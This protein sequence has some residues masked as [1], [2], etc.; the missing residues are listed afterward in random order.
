MR[1]KHVAIAIVAGLLVSTLA[2]ARSIVLLQPPNYESYGISDPDFD[3]SFAEDFVLDRDMLVREVVVWGVR[4]DPSLEDSFTLIFR[5]DDNGL[6]GA[7]TELA[8]NLVPR[9]R[10]TTGQFVGTLA[11]YIYYIQ[12]PAPVS[13][14]RGIWWVEIFNA[15]PSPISWGW[16]GGNWDPIHGRHGCAIATEAP[17]I[18]WS[19]LHFHLSILIV[20]SPVPI[21]SDGFESGD[22]DAWSYTAPPI[23]VPVADFEYATNGLE[24]TFLN[25]STGDQPLAYLW[26]FG[27]GTSPWNRTDTNPVHTYAN[28]ATYTVT[29]TVTNYLGADSVSKKVTVS[30]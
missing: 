6:P 23:G 1:A 29:L 26:D 7:V 2:T 9:A 10:S 13:L 4:A 11:E 5:E 27:D 19:F 24:V 30:Q 28:P 16:E 3:R 17:G 22:T 12:L 25:T 18:N 14:S 15:T 8:S 21:F 20:G